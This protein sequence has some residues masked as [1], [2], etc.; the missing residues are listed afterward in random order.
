MR[1]FENR[2]KLG[3]GALG[4]FAA[5]L[6]FLF[7]GGIPSYAAVSTST[8]DA[9]TGVVLSE[10]ELYI[11]NSGYDDAADCTAT[12][13]LSNTSYTMSASNTTFSVTSSNAS[14]VIASAT[15]EEN[16]ITLTSYTPGT[17]TLTI[18]VGD[19][20]FCVDLTVADATMSDT[21]LMAVGGS[22]SL[23]VTANSGSSDYTLSDSLIKWYSSDTSVVTVDSNGNLKA[24]KKGNA[25]V[26][27]VVG[28]VHLGCA[29][30]VTSAKK[31][32]AIK[33]AISIVSVSSYSQA[34]RMSKGYYDCSSL[35]FRAYKN[36]GLTVV[37]KR[38]SYAPVAATIAKWLI[39]TKHHK[40]MK[41][42]TSG[43]QSMKYY[44]GDLGFQTG[45]SNGRY[46]GIYH[47]EIFRGYAYMGYEN[48]KA[49]LEPCW[50]NRYTGYRT[51][52][53]V[54]F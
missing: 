48:G 2:L 10:S 47:V 49:V 40:K 29:V 4:L 17:T 12:L 22:S 39:C 43:I 33:K 31:V 20:V 5:V 13:E 28:D 38:I 16:V 41:L 14:V 35:V 23:Y 36:A 52:I 11:I 21:K 27:A 26:Y 19:S 18:T 7:I 51:K 54:H 34:R 50:A 15:L 32:K 3:V 53:I 24:K 45:A 25:I 30:S 44:A 6:L 1:Y 8:S 42:T 9:V 46:L 37:S